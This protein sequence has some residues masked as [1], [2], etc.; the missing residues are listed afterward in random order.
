MEIVTQHYRDSFWQGYSFL[1]RN[2][3]KTKENFG[4]LNYVF[5][6]LSDL[7]LYYSH[8]LEQICNF[9]R[10]LTSIL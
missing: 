2:F 9:I 4:Q 8:N 10:F 3:C 7:H 1:K 5:S 6:R